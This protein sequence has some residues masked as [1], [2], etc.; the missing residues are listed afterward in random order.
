MYKW[1]FCELLPVPMLIYFTCVEFIVLK[2]F[3]HRC[4]LRVHVIIIIT[5]LII[6]TIWLSGMILITPT[7][8]QFVILINYSL[9]IVVSYCTAT[10][11]LAFLFYTHHC[12]IGD[13]VYSILLC[14]WTF[15]ISF[16][17]CVVVILCVESL[18]SA[19]FNV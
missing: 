13:I 19:T 8:L 5:I 11:V 7:L 12:Y 14:F 10:I 1:L 15:L 2:L 9:H 17:V 4:R 16:F 6:V 18:G 3:K